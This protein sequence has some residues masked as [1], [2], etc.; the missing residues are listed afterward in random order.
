[1][2]PVCIRMWSAFTALTSLLWWTVPWTVREINASSLQLLPSRYLLCQQEERLGH[3]DTDRSLL[4]SSSDTEKAGSACVMSMR[5]WSWKLQPQSLLTPGRST[6]KPAT[7]SVF[8]SLR[9]LP[10]PIRRESFSSEEISTQQ[11]NMWKCPENLILLK[12]SF[13]RAHFTVCLTVS[14]E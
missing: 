4:K 14:Q 9:S 1:M 11:I 5:W 3:G 2:F 10:S 12:F 8:L 6:V 13:K 7:F